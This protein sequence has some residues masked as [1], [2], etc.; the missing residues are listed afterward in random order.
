MFARVVEIAV[1]TEKK[2]DFLQTM[3]QEILPILKQQ[4]G[5]LELL[6]LMPVVANERMCALT[7]WSDKGDADQYAKDVFPR[8]EQILKPFLTIPVWVR[9]YTVETSFCKRLVEVLTQAA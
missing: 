7:F 5:F 4:P 1:K 9:I 3:R 8:L 6:P 2:E